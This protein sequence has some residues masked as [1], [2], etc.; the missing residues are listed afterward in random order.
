MNRTVLGQVRK[1]ASVLLTPQGRP[2]GE[3]LYFGRA[4][5]SHAFDKAAP[6]PK[7]IKQMCLDDNG[8]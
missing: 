1:R 7:G 2:Y 5:L 3:R 8:T 6:Q 4:S